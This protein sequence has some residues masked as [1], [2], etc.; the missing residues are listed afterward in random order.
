MIQKMKTSLV[1]RYKLDLMQ[2]QLC[3]QLQAQLEQ[4]E[5]DQI[6]LSNQI[7]RLV[8]GSSHRDRIQSHN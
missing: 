7:C 1:S 8:S 4:R 5:C 2:I 3:D 6:A